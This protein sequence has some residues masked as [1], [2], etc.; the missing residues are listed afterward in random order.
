MSAFTAAV[1]GI[2]LVTAAG[3]TAAETWERVLQGVPGNVGPIP[4]LAGLAYDFGYSV[5][6]GR[7][8]ADA[9]LGRS[10][11][12]TMERFAQLAVIAARE[13]LDQAGISTEDW[14]ATRVAVVIG[15]AHGGLD[16]Y[17]D[18]TAMM[19]A[20]G[21]R[22]VSP[23]VTPLSLLNHA[24]ASVSL[25]T[26]ARGPSMGMA[27][28][29]A[30]GTSAIGHARL[31]LRAG[32]CDIAIAG[33]AESMHSRTLIASA[34]RAGTVSTHR[35]DPAAACRPFGADRDGM[36]MGEG[37]G[38]L[39]LEH[40]G[41][42]RARGA[43]VLARVCGYG[44]ANDAHSPAVPHPE[45]AGLEQA[46]R[47]ALADA[48]EAGVAPE[49]IGHVNAHGTG[50]VANDAIEA[51]ALHRVLGT[52]PLVASTKAVTGHTLGA[53]GA[54]ETALTVLALRDQVVPPTANLDALD[55]EI[56]VTL[57]AKRARPTRMTA[58]VKTSLGFGGHNA[59][60]VLTR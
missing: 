46:L 26:G 48:A 23:M 43:R 34:I 16:V 54:I 55:P 28:S 6:P 40:P 36:V 59:A 37:A 19:R 56:R 33:G 41:H 57:Q 21:D 24:A 1:T 14:N 18:A 45:G 47:T 25:D 60:L 4:Q 50:T 31:L 13:A 39:V 15:S 3:V 7:L 27:A 10:A 9:L 51:A 2:G 12:R 58:A 17:D 42:A 35:H 52:G 53:A 32:L 44:S 8:D 5:P 49:D 38:V 22:R 20:K 11:A 30:S 29:C